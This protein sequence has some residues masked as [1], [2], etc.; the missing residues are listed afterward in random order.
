MK[1]WLTPALLILFLMCAPA[2]SVQ[3][4]GDATEASRIR[5]KGDYV[6][7]EILVKF[8]PQ[9]RLSA[10]SGHIQQHGL[11][12]LQSFSA[13]GVD[14]LKLP[15]EMTVEE[16][17][18]LLQSDPNVEYAEP[19]YTYRITAVPNDPYFGLLWGLHNTGQTV[20][21]IAGTADADMDAVEAWDRNTGRADVIVAVVD[22]G[23]LRSH[24]D[25][26]ANIWV[27]PAEIPGNG[28][29]DDLNGLVDDINGW[30]FVFDDNDP[31]D[32]NG[33]GTHVAGTIAAI[34]NNGIGVTGVSWNAKIMVLRAFDKDGFG[35]LDAELKS[36]LYAISKGAHV[37]NNSWGGSS[38]AQSLKD[39]ID[40]SPAVVVC[41]AGNGGSDGLGD[42]NDVSPHYPSNYSSANI[43]AVAATNQNDTLASFSNYGPNNVDVAAPGTNILSTTNDG[44]YNYKQGT[45]MATPHVS[46]LAALLWGFTWTSANEDRLKA[47][48]DIIYRIK[49]TV[50]P[51]PSLSGLIA[52]SGRINA[53]RALGGAG[54][55]DGDGDDEGG[56]GCFIATAAFG[57]YAEPHVK[58]LRDFRDR[59]LKP[60]AWGRIFVRFYYQHSPEWASFIQ[61]NESLRRAIR[62]ALIPVAGLAGLTLSIGLLPLLTGLATLMLLAAFIHFRIRKA[63]P[64]GSS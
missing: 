1:K 41:A 28:I 12:S 13:I 43:L 6:P 10:L 37:I 32:A 50:D 29:D 2:A 31:N 61:E 64:S 15:E 3:A 21:G 56:G 35:S 34:G 11:A 63:R 24:P 55:G 47:A 27:N 54:D 52:T 58:T 17:L 49:S 46:G 48:G 36:I 39:A 62:L 45:S 20:N 59:Y 4:E 14:H 51:L 30:D 8:K 38:Y 7:G 25:L 5:A 26:A 23:V 9:T 33:H 40:A 57:S 22:S 44:I 60:N 16:A 42:N 19:N 18:K 53:S